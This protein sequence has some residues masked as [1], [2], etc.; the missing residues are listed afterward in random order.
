MSIQSALEFSGLSDTGLVR[1]HNEDCI[2]I[3]PELGLAVLADGMGGYQAGEV[4][5]KMCVDILEQYFNSVFQR[6]I[7]SAWIQKFSRKIPQLE[8]HLNDAIS[9]A[10]TRI[11]QAAAENEL[12][13]EWVP[14]SS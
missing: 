11:F 10:N 1:A 7:K 2:K 3:C 5:S 14:Q 8:K 9:L 4:A 6:K 12:F 13:L